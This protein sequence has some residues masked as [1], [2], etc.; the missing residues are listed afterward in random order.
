[1]GPTGMGPMTGRGAGYCAGYGAPGFA[2]PGMGMGRGMGFG[3]GGRGRRNMFYATGMPGWARIGAA[4]AP[5]VDAAGQA[6]ALRA[7][8]LAL[9]QAL[10]NVRERLAEMEEAKKE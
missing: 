5:A 2:N 6:L 1:M 10:Q 9:E 8:A 4:P 3:G 7:Q